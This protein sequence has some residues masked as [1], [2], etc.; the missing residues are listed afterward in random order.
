MRGKIRLWRQALLSS[1]NLDTKLGAIPPQSSFCRFMTPSHIDTKSGFILQQVVLVTVSVWCL[2]GFDSTHGSHRTAAS[3]RQRRRTPPPSFT[4]RKLRRLGI[5]IKVPVWRCFQPQICD[6]EKHCVNQPRHLAVNSSDKKTATNYQRTPVA[7]PAFCVGRLKEGQAIF[8]GGGK[9]IW[10]PI[11]H[12]HNTGHILHYS[13]FPSLSLDLSFL[14][15]SCDSFPF[16]IF[17]IPISRPSS[18]FDT[19]S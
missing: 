3:D 13:K 5:G 7:A 4:G 12:F 1:P 2:D 14:F 10:S 9:S 11:T 15:A 18:S 6:A 17:F 16:H 8:R 19:A